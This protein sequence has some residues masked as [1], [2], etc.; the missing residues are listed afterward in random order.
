MVGCLDALLFRGQHP[1]DAFNCLNLL[2]IANASSLI[3]QHAC[4]TVF[5]ACFEVD[6]GWPCQG[7]HG[8]EE[9][10]ATKEVAEGAGEDAGK[11]S[12]QAEAAAAREP[13]RGTSTFCYECSC[14]QL[15]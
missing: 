11:G 4:S 6:P 9:K 1:H 13:I 10:R 12:F 8:H 5:T 15:G 2:P 7:V 3:N 14:F